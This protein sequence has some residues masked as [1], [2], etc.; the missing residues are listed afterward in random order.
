[1]APARQEKNSDAIA[2]IE[3]YLR[4]VTPEEWEC[5]DAADT[6]HNI[7]GRFAR[8]YRPTYKRPDTALRRERARLIAEFQTHLDQAI[9]AYGELNDFEKHSI[10]KGANYNFSAP[11]K[12][13]VYPQPFASDISLIAYLKRLRDAARVIEQNLSEY[14]R[15]PMLSVCACDA[16]DLVNQLCINPPTLT[17]DS[18]K[19]GGAP[20]FDI[21]RALYSFSLGRDVNVSEV[22]RTCK[23]VHGVKNGK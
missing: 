1:V 7:V 23:S 15:D 22:E 12:E 2:A 21:T 19:D 11:L 8:V 20:F 16:Y 10:F 5:V 18:K 17:R 3:H 6:L 13:Q 4:L 9:E 14:K